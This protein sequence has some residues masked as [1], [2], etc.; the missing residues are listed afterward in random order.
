VREE[1]ENDIEPPVSLM[2]GSETRDVALHCVQ[3]LKEEVQEAADEAKRIAR[4]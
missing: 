1:T 2:H 4:E 3:V